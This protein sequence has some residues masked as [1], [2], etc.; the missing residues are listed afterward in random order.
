MESGVVDRDVGQVGILL[1]AELDNV[2]LGVVVQWG[3]RGDLA[4]LGK[5]VLVDEEESPKYQPP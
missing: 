3:E 2:S 1:Q 4:D 5:N